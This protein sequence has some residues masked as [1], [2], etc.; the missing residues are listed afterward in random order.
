[1]ETDARPHVLVQGTADWHQPIATNQHYMARELSKEFDITFVE[2]LGLRRPEINLRDFIRVWRRLVG[3][4]TALSEMR[5]T[6]N[7]LRVVSP[8]VVPNHSGPWRALNGML[9]ARYFDDWIR[10]EKRVFWTYSPVTYGFESRADVALYHCV[11]LYG[12]FPGIDSGLVDKEERRLAAAGV[13]AAGSSEVVVDHLRKQGFRTVH[14]WPNVADTEEFTKA[15][16]SHSTPRSGAVFAGNLTEKK[17]D[18]DL[19][20]R[21]V[22]EGVELHLAGPDAEGGG[23]SKSRLAELVASGAKYH[24]MLNLQELSKLMV[25]CKVGLIPYKITPYTR[26]VSPLKT[27]EYLAAG[28]S[29]VSTLLPGVESLEPDVVLAEDG[30]KFVAATKRAVLAPENSVANRIKIA[31]GH[32]W[33]GRGETARSVIQ[34][35]MPTSWKST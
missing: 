6:P 11:D 3:N 28:L 30:D 9:L 2:S 18:F 14:Y 35:L 10:S 5:M 13:I 24:G 17:V 29:V 32:S 15:M 23:S 31:E 27:Y 33:A 21:L 8:K 34:G 12:T 25:K 7:N 22:T 4:R 26:G 16:P 19:L 1:M 20:M